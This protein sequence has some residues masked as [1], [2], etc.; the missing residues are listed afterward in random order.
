[1]STFKNII[2][3]LL[4]SLGGCFHTIH[5]DIPT[6]Q[7]IQKS[8]QREAQAQAYFQEA[9]AYLNQGKTEKALKQFN[10][11]CSQYL[12]TAIAPEAFFICGE[13]LYKQG[14]INQAFEKFKFITKNYVN[15]HHYGQVVEKEFDLACEIMKRYNRRSRLHFLSFFKNEN[16][17]IDCFRHIVT[18]AP[19][20]SKAAIALFHIA[21]LERDNGNKVKAIEA[22]TQ[23]IENYPTHP[24]AADAYLLQ[25]EIYLSLVNSPQNDQGM[26]RN[27]IHCYEDFLQIYS[28]D[29]S[30]KAKIAL[31]HKKL[32]EIRAFYGKSRLVLGDFFLFRRHYPQGAV[33]FYNE[34]QLLAPFTDIAEKAQQRIDFIQTGK[35]TP[36][37]WADFCFG[38]VIHHSPSSQIKR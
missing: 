5:N 10:I 34:A 28:Q 12:E 27:S 19:Q 6:S 26:T 35:E 37:N 38:K 3:V 20:S 29:E 21:Q 25:G 22:L 11:I 30:L 15:Y 7:I 13:E 17:A 31:A 9:N 32:Q 14:K 4:L 36:S 18:M 23:L 33:I 2:Y 24:Y 1:M 16:E 8:P